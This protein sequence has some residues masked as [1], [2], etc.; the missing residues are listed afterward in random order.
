MGRETTNNQLNL[1]KKTI[2]VKDAGSTSKTVVV[3]VPSQVMAAATQMGAKSPQ[4]LTRYVGR[5][6]HKTN[7]FL[8][9]KLR[10]KVPA[11]FGFSSNDTGIELHLKLPKPAM[12]R[13]FPGWIKCHKV[14]SARIIALTV[15]V[16]LLGSHISG[17]KKASSDTTAVN[18]KQPA[19]VL[20]KGKPNYDTILPQGK[21]ANT[22]G[23]WTRISPPGRNPVYA[24]VDNLSTVQITVSEQPLP[25]NFKE[26]TNASIKQ[27]AEGFGATAKFSA[28][29][30]P[31]YIGTA[32]QGT[33]SVILAKN[34][35]LILIKS[36]A[37]IPDNQWI[38]YITNLQ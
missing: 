24:F 38:T 27:L 6:I 28:G 32:A 4:K 19:V 16:V 3:H 1:F 17:G 21:T 7:T 20:T 23:G 33:Q 9:P 15:L 11:G 18:P 10:P 31:F 36:V 12:V 2:T 35:L 13:Q 26:D 5:L 14:L 29:D 25:P 30:T 22:L 37:P 34:N 8:K